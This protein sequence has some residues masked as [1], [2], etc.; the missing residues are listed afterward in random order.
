MDIC[1]D[2]RE[3]HRIGDVG[4]GETPRGCRERSLA[5]DSC[6]GSRWTL[7]RGA[8]RGSYAPYKKRSTS[9]GRSQ[10]QGPRPLGADRSSPGRRRQC[11]SARRQFPSRTATRR[12]LVSRSGAR[13]GSRQCRTRR[14]ALTTRRLAGSDSARIADSNRA[15]AFGRTFTWLTIVSVSTGTPDGQDGSAAGTATANSRLAPRGASGAR[16][17]ATPASAKA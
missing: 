15:S 10:R 8:G 16:M 14:G 6:Q 17:L 12:R 11:R 7:Q 9:A 1:S 3:Q 13:Q 2:R 5:G 4:R